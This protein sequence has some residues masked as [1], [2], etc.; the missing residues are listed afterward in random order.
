M[1]TINKVIL[2]GNVTKD[3]FVKTTNLDKK[4]AT[5]TIATNRYY[6]GPNGE[7]LSEAEYTNCVVWGPLADRTE[8][9]LVKGK[10]VYIEGRLKTRIIDR[11]D[12]TKLYKTEVVVGQLIFLSKREDFETGGHES[13]DP[14]EFD[15]FS[16]LDGGKF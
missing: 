1:R 4:I 6:K 10:L 5:F 9:F 16:D 8:Q 2:I 7:P 15:D 3:P 14:V 11:E 12:G 13:I